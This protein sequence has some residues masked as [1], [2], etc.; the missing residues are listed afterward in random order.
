MTLC[1]DLIRVSTV[2]TLCSP[3]S[4]HIYTFTL[5]A[6]LT[7]AATTLHAD[8]MTGDTGMLIR[9][10]RADLSGLYLCTRLWQNGTAQSASIRLS[11]T[12][13]E[14]ARLAL[15]KNREKDYRRKNSINLTIE[16][17]LQG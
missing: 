13:G 10:M 8:I 5:H 4:P 2:V 14:T 7:F 11:L 16:E 12:D 9:H 15:M 6:F 17:R 3:L 1:S